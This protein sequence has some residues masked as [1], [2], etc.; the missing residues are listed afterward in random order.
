MEY[1]IP[2]ECS[3][4]GSVERLAVGAFSGQSPADAR[5]GP[6]VSEKLSAA[7]ALSHRYEPAGANAPTDDVHAVVSG[8]V[9][10]AAY[11]R[12]VSDVDAAG[13]VRT[14]TVA[15]TVADADNDATLAAVNVTRQGQA[16]A[17]EATADDLVDELIGRCVDAFVDSITPRRV[18][19]A[20]R[21]RRGKS[22]H[23]RKAASLA[24]AGK[25]EAAL[26]MYARAIERHPADHGSL[27]GAGVMCEAM[28]RIEQ[29][30]VY[31]ARA[32]ELADDED[33]ARSL[34][35]VQR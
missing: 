18:S 21:L 9:R 27:F 32:T 4:P 20:E 30:R 23:A 1:E 8:S 7:L 2:A 12:H 26:D 22:G 10:V 13:D 11:R 28:G 29:A 24:A 3:L 25:Y 19:T 33:Y 6:V 17:D 16:A 34:D 35:R 15:F 31:Y 5:W 14:V